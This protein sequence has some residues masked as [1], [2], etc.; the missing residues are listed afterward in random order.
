MGRQDLE[1]CFRSCLAAT[2][3]CDDAPGMEGIDDQYKAIKT[4][5]MSKDPVLDTLPM[6]QYKNADIVDCGKGMQGK[7]KSPRVSTLTS[8][9]AQKVGWKSVP[10]SS[11]L[12]RERPQI[13]GRKTVPTLKRCSLAASGTMSGARACTA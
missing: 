1:Q 8:G 2:C 5:D 11:S 12:S 9:A 13:S 4:N 10:T 6:W 7:K 3:G